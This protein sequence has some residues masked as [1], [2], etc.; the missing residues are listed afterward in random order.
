[1]AIFYRMACLFMF[2]TLTY[3]FSIYKRDKLST[4]RV[5]P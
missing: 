3:S 5:T 1:M 2:A 4:N